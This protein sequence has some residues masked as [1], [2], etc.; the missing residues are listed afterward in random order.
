M[1]T[2]I[3]GILVCTLLIATVLPVGGTINENSIFEEQQN[4]I[5]T[6]KN[7]QTESDTDWWPMF[8]HDP[9]NT[10]CSSSLAPNTNELT[11]KES[12][13]DEIYSTTPVVFNDRL[14]ISTNWYYDI[15]D[16][17][18]ITKTPI[19]EKPSLFEIIE[20][21][22]TYKDKYYGGV[23][24]LNADNGAPL[25]NQQMYLPNDPAVVDDDVYVTDFGI[26]SYF[27]T[28]Y[29]LDAG[30]GS[31]NWQKSMD[32]LVFSPTIVAD[33]K[34]Y[35]GCLD[36]YSYYGTLECLDLNGNDIWTYTL[37]P[38]EV[39]WNSAPAVCDGKVYF[40]TSDIYSYSSGNLY[41][42]NA[43]TGQYLWS[44][45]ITSSFYSYYG[46][47]SPVCADGK[48]YAYDFDM[49]GYYGYLKCFD[50]ETG[51][52]IWS[53]NIGW[54]F[55][56]PAVC[57]DSIY[58]TSL[59][60]YSYMSWLYRINKDTGALI[61]K[62]P[63]PGVV[64][65]YFSS[66]PA[67]GDSMIYMS[68][69]DFYSYSTTIYCYD[70]DDGSLIW[71]YILDFL[72]LSSPSIAD[73][74][75]Y[76]SDYMGNIYA[77]GVRNEPPTAPTIDGPTSGTAGEEYCWTFHSTDPD[78]DDVYY[79]IYW[80][81]GQIEN[82]IGPY[83]SCTPVEICHTYEEQGTYDIQARAKD[84]NGAFSDWGHLEVEMPVNQHSTHVFQFL[85]KL[86]QRF[87][88]AFPILR[89]GLGL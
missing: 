53:Y 6:T 7:G 22:M 34:I 61:W 12:I 20:D 18:N 85:E 87:P 47:P 62:I 11:W 52:P 55:S 1:K 38:D 43:E 36:L 27:S 13:W 14:Y 64:Y 89:H 50:A 77:F 39:I 24:C 65:F 63:L 71:S 32:G 2:K 23:Y 51:N 45:P 19:S 73:G 76:M 78:D 25:W 30:T 9:G 80:G 17:P 41:C 81:D 44:Q 42:L 83:P 84:V 54:A 40:V 16:P 46:S 15:V 75:V 8:R 31:S 28:L 21:I 58:I 66:A 67:V 69:L 86:M 26:Y 56:T 60:L 10:G 79:Y 57:G 49:Y 35:L 70:I 68:T 37:G 33:D 5:D 3:L 59:D 82:W 74:R 4:L 72:S 29:C 88:N 48:V